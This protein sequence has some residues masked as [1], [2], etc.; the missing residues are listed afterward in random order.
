MKIKIK[1]YQYTTANG[2]LERTELPQSNLKRYFKLA[3][4]YCFKLINYKYVN[5]KDYNDKPIVKE[6]LDIRGLRTCAYEGNGGQVVI[7]QFM[8]KFGKYYI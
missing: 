7:A 2:K 5:A 6:I 8:W 3:L 4:L 1:K